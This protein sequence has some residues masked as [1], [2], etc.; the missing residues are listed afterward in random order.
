[1]TSEPIA[2]QIAERLGSGLLTAKGERAFELALIELQEVRLRAGWLR[3]ALTVRD[4]GGQAARTPLM[5]G[6]ISGGGRGVMPWCEGRIYPWVEFINHERFDTRQTGLEAE[7]IR[8]IGSLVPAGGHLMLEYE[9]P[10]QSET[11]RELL[12]R[13]PPA[14]THLGALMFTAGFR[15]RFKDWYISEGGHE[16]PRKLQANKSPN[17]A[18]ARDALRFNLDELKQFIRRQPP[19]NAEDAA[20]VARAQDRARLLLKEFSSSYR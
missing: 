10:G 2:K 5:T 7:L 13:V 4:E 15:G 16:G 17:A 19:E 12:L 8:L 6:L 20:L 14:A 9:S 11:H 18:A 1:M 3:F